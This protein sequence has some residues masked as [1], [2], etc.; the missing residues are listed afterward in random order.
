[1]RIRIGILFIFLLTMFPVTCLGQ[2][3]VFSMLTERYVDR[4]IA[5]HRGQLQINTGYEFSTLSKIF[6]FKGN[7]LDL[8]EEGI[9]S[10][11]HLF[12]L[13][14]KYG[15]LEF[16]Q[17]RT[18]LNY[19]RMNLRNQNLNFETYTAII[20]RSE[21]QTWKGF[22]DLFLGTDLTIPFLPDVMCWVVSAGIYLPIFNHEPDQPTHTINFLSPYPDSMDIRY[23]YHN[24][25]GNGVPVIMLGTSLKLR[26][27]KFDVE[28]SFHI[29]KGLTVV[30][31]I[32]WQSRLTGG[33][34]EY[35]EI[36]YQYD[37]GQT[38]NYHSSIA[39]QAIN[40]L[41]VILS[42][43]GM[44]SYGGWTTETGKKVGTGKKSLNSLCVGYDIQVSPHFRLNQFIDIP[45]LGKNIMAYWIFQTGLSLNFIVSGN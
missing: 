28:S 17:V 44:T 3:D 12:P 26:F 29:E 2:D 7:I 39:Y 5:M 42:Y 24:K 16:L 13:D 40:W 8:G 30:E 1:M 15:I 11:K 34:I 18:S 33:K 20:Y 22:D 23:Q 25:F 14:I 31:S 21:I 27:S 43:N 32:Y 36:P 37:L 38:L 45:I 4:P 19:A 35:R 41:A 6:D 10:A 9:A